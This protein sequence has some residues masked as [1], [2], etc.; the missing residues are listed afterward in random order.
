MITGSSE[1]AADPAAELE[2]VRAGEHQVEDDEIEARALDQPRAR[3]AVA[4]L[5]RAVALT[6]EI[7]DDDLAHDRLVVDDEDGCHRRSCAPAMSV[8]PR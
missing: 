6:G 2:P 1:R 8:T 7:A 4:G 3:V 5:E